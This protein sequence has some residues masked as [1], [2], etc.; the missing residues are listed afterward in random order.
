MLLAVTVV[1]GRRQY[2]KNRADIV[3]NPVV[4]VELLSDAPQGYDCVANPNWTATGR[5]RH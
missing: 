2:H 1:C 5:F 3:T 4:I